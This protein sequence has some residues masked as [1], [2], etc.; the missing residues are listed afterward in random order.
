MKFPLRHTLLA[1]FSMLAA[2]CT[3]PTLVNRGDYYADTS[4]PARSVDS[5]I[6]FLVMHYTEIGEAPSL[7]V[8]TQENV[9]AHYVVPDAPRTERGAPVVYQL[10]PESERAWHAGVSAWQGATELN[11]V[12]IGIENVNRGPI[13]TP[14][15]RMWAPYPPAQVDAIVRLAKDI[16][17]R[18][19]IPPTRVVGHSDIAP[20]RKI[21]PGPLFPWRAL[22]KAGVGAWPADEWVAAR[23]AGRPPKSLVEVRRIDHA[24]AM[25]ASPEQGYFVRENVKLRLLSARLSLLARDDGAMK[26]D[27]HAAQA[28]VARYFDG[29]SKDTRVVQDLLKQVDAASLTVAVPNLNTS[30]NA[31]QQFKSRG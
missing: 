6:R 28:A 9:S 4:L 22:A 23:L 26:S 17:A 8:L 27:L 16:V 24:D 13:D 12:S 31:V 14:H 29:A 5:R 2:A 1:S 11:G 30:L 7:R 15:G 10:V 19:R 18:Y 25:L 20:Q 3:T 21:D